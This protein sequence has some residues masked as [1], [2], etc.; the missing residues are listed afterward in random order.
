[1]KNQLKIPANVITRP[2]PWRSLSSAL[3]LSIVLTSVANANVV[4]SDMQLFNPT[5]DGLDFVTVES[6]ETL[7]PGYVNFGLFMN[8]AVNTLPYFEEDGQKQSKTKFNDSVLAADLN[9]GIGVSK[10]FS[11]GLSLPQILTQT[12]STE[13]YNGK[14]RDN[15]NT[16]V[17]VNGKYRIFGDQDGGIALGGAV[18]FNRTKDNPYLGDSSAPIY[19]A[20]LFGDKRLSDA[21]TAG[22]NLGYRWRKSAA[23]LPDAAPIKPLPNQIIGSLAASY[24]MPEIDTKIVLL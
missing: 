11:L 24:H 10:D 19:S 22:L 21:L 4:G 15:G 1:M 14:F 23:A 20:Q 8:Y 12:V 5:T 9:V 18:S 13:G 17:R 7:L 3:S 16:E 6:S 2:L